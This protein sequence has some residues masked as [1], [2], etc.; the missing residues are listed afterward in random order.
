MHLQCSTFI[1]NK[2]TMTNFQE[3]NLSALVS[4]MVQKL[5][6]LLDSKIIEGL[7]RKGF[8]FER[9]EDFVAFIKTRMTAEDNVFMNR[10]TY[11]VDGVPFFVHYYSDYNANVIWFEEKTSMSANF[12]SFQ[13]L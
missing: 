13:F 1:N 8:T 7:Q 5:T 12:G 6:E 11:F 2:T 3:I 9:K 10:K 4:E